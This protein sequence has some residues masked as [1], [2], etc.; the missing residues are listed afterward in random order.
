MAMGT[1][2]VP[3]I[4]EVG[5]DGSTRY[6]GPIE[7]LDTSQEALVL[8]ELE[9][10]IWNLRLVS[11]DLDA[12]RELITRAFA[13]A[14]GGVR[15]EL[16]TYFA[17]PDNDPRLIAQ[18]GETRKVETINV[19]QLP[20]SENVFEIR[21]TES[22]GSRRSFGRREKHHYRALAKVSRIT[23]QTPSALLYNPLGVVITELNW[24]EVDP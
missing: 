19:L 6:A 10:F 21:W 8:H 17:Q 16:E 20:D 9:E 13:L 23:E 18:R 15:S 2:V 12:Q 24:S 22:H 11:S 5:A 4:V 3:Y 1:Q 7:S 14:D